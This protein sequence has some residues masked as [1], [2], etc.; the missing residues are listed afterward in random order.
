MNKFIKEIMKFVV[1]ICFTIGGFLIFK[2][3]YNEEEH[4]GSQNQ[5]SDS[6][7]ETLRKYLVAHQKPS[8]IE[9]I[10]LS[11]RFDS[12]VNEIKKLKIAQDKNSNFYL[13]IQ[14]FTDES[15]LKAPLIAQIRFIEVNSGNTIKEESLNLE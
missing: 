6:K 11:K 9:I 2:K 3:Y 13:M 10:N 5:S 14:F 12:E 7:T 8:R 4:R 15:D 1:I